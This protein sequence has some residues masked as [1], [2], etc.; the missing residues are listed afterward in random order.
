[1]EKRSVR[2]QEIM[3]AVFS[4]FS[5]GFFPAVADAAIVFFIFAGLSPVIFLP[6][7]L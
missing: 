7:L 5:F 6:I 3:A 2:L 1:M 4:V